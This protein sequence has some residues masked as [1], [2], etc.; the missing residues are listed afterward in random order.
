ML[1]INATITMLQGTFVTLNYFEILIGSRH[2][3]FPFLFAATDVAC[4]SK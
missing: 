3:I 4:S 1:V 2:D